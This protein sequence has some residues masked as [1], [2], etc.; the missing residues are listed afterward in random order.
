MMPRPRVLIVDDEPLARERLVTLLQDIGGYEVIGQ[1]GDGRSAIDLVQTASADIVL[2]DIRMPVMDGLEAARH[3][4]LQ[5]NPPAIIFTTA[6]DDHALAAFDAHALDYLLKPIRKER[7]Q[8]GLLRASAFNVSQADKLQPI[9]TTARTQLSINEQGRLQ[10]IDVNSI[11]YFQA[12]QKYVTIACPQTN[13]LFEES[14]KSLE[15][16]F[17][18]QF[19]R[20]HRN[21]LVAI[22][23][24]ESLQKNNDG[25]WS[26]SLKDMQEPL[27]VSRRH[28]SEVRNRLK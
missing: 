16:E 8:Q 15:V 19:L 5:E 12:D 13:Y 2:L 24:V 23:H 1:C 21:A 14:L 26:V 27:T 17:A 3:L 28:L 9:D 25:S 22:R 20:V 10:R 11:R 7:L 4:A 18:E 6:Y